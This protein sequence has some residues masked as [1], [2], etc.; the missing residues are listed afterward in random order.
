MLP[1]PR[2][3]QGSS[4]SAAN[5]HPPDTARRRSRSRPP[6]QYV[7]A[8]RVATNGGLALCDCFPSPQLT[9]M[10]A[11]RIRRTPTDGLAGWLERRL[12]ARELHYRGAIAPPGVLISALSGSRSRRDTKAGGA[13][14]IRD[15][16]VW[17]DAPDAVLVEKNRFSAQVAQAECR[18][19]SRVRVSPFGRRTAPVMRISRRCRRRRR[20]IRCRHD[21]DSRCRR[22]RDRRRRAVREGQSGGERG[23][24]TQ[25]APQL[26]ATCY[27]LPHHEQPRPIKIAP[28]SPRST[29]QGRGHAFSSRYFNRQRPVT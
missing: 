12:A 15:L 6:S 2:T 19:R 16:V 3:G 25:H 22:S 11:P 20:T 8:R 7:R 27:S 10:D 26:S 23:D 21:L 1:R 18:F 4:R 13:G 28:V 17:L 5:V 24:R 14:R 9:S 29:E